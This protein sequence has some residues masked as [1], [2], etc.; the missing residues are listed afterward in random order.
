M[1]LHTLKLVYGSTQTELLYILNLASDGHHV[2]S[3][4]Q[5]LL[6]C[7]H[8]DTKFMSQLWTLIALAAGTYIVLL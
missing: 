5:V 6:P 4:L 1:K 7:L 8:A 2:A 3:L